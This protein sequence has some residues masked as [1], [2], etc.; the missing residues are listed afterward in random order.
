MSDIEPKE[1][2]VLDKGLCVKN[3][4]NEIVGFMPYTHDEKN[5]IL[6]ELKVIN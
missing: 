2:F 4:R 6:H 3:G 1:V 5:L